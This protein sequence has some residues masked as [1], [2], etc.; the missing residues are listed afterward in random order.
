MSAQ[1]EAYIRTWDEWGRAS[2]SRVSV[3]H[4]HGE[5]RL[6]VGRHAYEVTDAVEACRGD[7]YAR[8][9]LADGWVLCSALRC[10]LTALGLLEREREE[11]AQ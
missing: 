9:E 7:G 2:S 4:L 6:V 3:E 8:F 5:D 1:R 11:V 10:A